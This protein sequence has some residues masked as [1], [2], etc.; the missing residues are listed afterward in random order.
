MYDNN[1]YHSSHI[2]EVLDVKEKLIYSVFSTEEGKH[3]LDMM[4][5][6][7]QEARW[8]AGED[9]SL[10]HYREGWCAYQRYILQTVKHFE[11]DY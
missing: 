2:G 9:A 1:E 5:E 11:E 8:F 10:G 7:L 6:E 4:K 3:L